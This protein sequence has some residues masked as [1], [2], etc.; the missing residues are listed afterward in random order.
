MATVPIKQFRGIIGKLAFLRPQLTR[1]FLYLKPL[2]KASN[3]AA[4]KAGDHGRLRLKPALL[5][6]FLWC[7][8]EITH[9]TPR[10]LRP[11]VPQ[12]V[13]TTDAAETGVGGVLTLQQQ[14]LYMA[15]QLSEDGSSKS[16]N[17]RE[18]AAVWHSLKHFAP[19]LALHKI[20]VLTLESDNTTVVAN[21]AKI[22]S[23]PG[24]LKLVRRIF[25]W[26]IKPKIELLPVHK[27]GVLN[28]EA[29]ALSS[30]EWMG[31]YSVKW[32]P[33]A[34]TLSEWGVQP[35]I[36]LFATKAN[37]KLPRYAS[38]VVDPEAEWIDAFSRPWSKELPYVHPTPKLLNNCLRRIR[39]EKMRAI[40]LTPVWASHH[41]GTCSS[42]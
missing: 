16:S 26:L 18:L 39:E 41:G 3:T 15:R 20:S 40:V 29:D 24:P 22:K 31:D 11:L 21:L 19:T 2:Y 14:K 5:G 35:T 23:A 10:S 30:L 27:P 17:Q 33:I 34:Q 9:N 42:E 32:E 8:K 25:S 6:S 13:L 37:R 1:V 28:T 7:L 36:D 38:P 4:S 12:A